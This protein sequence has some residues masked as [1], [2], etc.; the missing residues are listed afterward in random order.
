MRILLKK[1]KGSGEGRE[2]T[3]QEEEWEVYIHEMRQNRECWKYGS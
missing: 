1:M 2:N 3:V